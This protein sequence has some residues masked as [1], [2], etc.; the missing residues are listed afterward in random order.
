MHTLPTLPIPEVAYSNPMAVLGGGGSVT[1][2]SN[3]LDQY[4]RAPHGHR[5]IDIHFGLLRRDYV[6]CAVVGLSRIR[7]K[8]TRQYEPSRVSGNAGTAHTPIKEE[9]PQPLR[10]GELLTMNSATMADTNGLSEDRCT[11]AYAQ[12]S[13]VN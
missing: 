4:I 5:V 1:A 9:T 13:I 3:C 2:D 7:T 10:A 6:M 8:Q 11:V 12:A